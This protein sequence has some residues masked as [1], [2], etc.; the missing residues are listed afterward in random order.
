MPHNPIPIT[1]IILPGITIGRNNVIGA[2]SVV[3]KD[4]PSNVVAFG[5]PCKIIREINENDKKFYYK[6]Y[7]V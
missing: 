2:G 5:N 3:A 7:K 4:I 6:N 1:V